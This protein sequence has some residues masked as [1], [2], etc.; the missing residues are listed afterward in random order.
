M[1]QFKDGSNCEKPS[2][3]AVEDYRARSLLSCARRGRWRVLR[4]R[5]AVHA[6][7]GG[8]IL[9]EEI[10]PE[11]H[12]SPGTL[13]APSTDRIFVY[14]DITNPDANML[15]IDPT[16]GLSL[17]YSEL[18]ERTCSRSVWMMTAPATIEAMARTRA[19]YSLLVEPDDS[20]SGFVKSAQNN[21]I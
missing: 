15:H 2:P 13:A 6:P 16:S 9:Y 11:H 21:R 8:S 10:K 12:S 3:A 7:R 20:F 19:P 5:G 18:T 4:P 1:E 14:R 17:S